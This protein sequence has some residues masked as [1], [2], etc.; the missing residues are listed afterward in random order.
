MK[1]VTILIGLAVLALAAV[2]S[3]QNPIVFELPKISPSPV[4][5]G[6]RGAAE[7]KDALDMECS[8]S[9]VLRD[10]AEYGWRDQALLQSNIS[11]NGLNLNDSAGESA[12]EAKTDADYSSHVFAAWDDEALWYVIEAR[13]NYRDVEG[14]AVL[15]NWWERDG[16]T[17]YIDLVN[18]RENIGC[19]TYTQAKMNLIKFDAAP[20]NSSSTT[21]TWERIVQ[22]LRTPTQDPTEIELLDYGFRDAG[23]EFGSSVTA[24]D[25]CIEGKVPWAHLLKGGL[26]AMPTAG[27]EVGWVW[28][29]PDPDNSDGYGG[30]IQCWGWG[31]LPVDYATVIFTDTPAG[32]GGT[33]VES[34]SW[35]AIKA[36]F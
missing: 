34:D 9:Q 20:R 19:C 27:Y 30:Q 2:A 3:A 15:T 28:L 8:P 24:A 22:D 36:T 29:A 12:A 1:K 14:T 26:P 23:E 5:D 18:S 13:D 7:C 17:L 35:G 33:A 32:A 10:G 11:N 16:M 4:L 25:Y 31:D 6:T 21:I